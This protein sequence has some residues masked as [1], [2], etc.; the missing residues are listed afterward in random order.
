MKKFL[1]LFLC[2][3]FLYSLLTFS[4]C[5]SKTKI[6][7]EAWLI[8]E[9][10]ETTILHAGRL[11]K[12]SDTQG[13]IIGTSWLFPKEATIFDHQ[14]SLKFKSDGAS[15]SDPLFVNDDPQYSMLVKY[16]GDLY[17]D[18]EYLPK[19][20]NDET[21]K[22]VAIC[23]HARGY[24]S[25]ETQDVLNESFLLGDIINAANI[26]NNTD[27]HTVRNTQKKKPIKYIYL[28]FNDC[29]AILNYGYIASLSNNSF[30]ICCFDNDSADLLYP[31]C[32]SSIAFLLQK[33]LL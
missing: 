1:S 7:G 28:S 16:A 24:R 5:T 11:Y 32:D 33:H 8:F 13:R 22:C 6:E 18:Q 29:M 14:I 10:G 4:A 27:V 9:E 17:C 15:C 12:K 3:L 23:N 26:D 31:L 20:I 25:V 19:T 2:L 21:I 30:G